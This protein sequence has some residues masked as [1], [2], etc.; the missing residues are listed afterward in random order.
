[1]IEIGL[2]QYPYPPETYANVFAQLTAIVHGEPPELP[3][4]KYSEQARDWVAKCMVKA[5]L[6][7]ATYK[8]LLVS[9]ALCFI[10]QYLIRLQEHPFLQA[11]AEREVDMVGWVAKALE[12][13]AVKAAETLQDQTPRS[14]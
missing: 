6:G 2:G 9:T 3:A 12:L 14:V 13:K 5:P 7:R 4:G 11:D 1:M 8:E 10:L